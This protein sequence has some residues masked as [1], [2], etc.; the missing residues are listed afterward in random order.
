VKKTSKELL[1]ERMHTVGGMPLKE[2]SIETTRP[3]QTEFKNLI[4]FLGNSKGYDI[5]FHTTRNEGI[6]KEI[7]QNGFQYKTFE[8]TTDPIINVVGL[9]YMLGI[10]KQYGNFTII[11]EMKNTIDYYAISK[12]SGVDEE[13]DEI[14]ILP[15]QY[16][17][18]YY[19][20]TTKEIYPNPLFKN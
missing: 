15:P 9:I 12:R 13:G 10:R 19:D 16:I 8:K 4:D 18:G 3:E 20:R 11:I 7:C 1:F 14:F 17:K 6:A 2:F 5:Y